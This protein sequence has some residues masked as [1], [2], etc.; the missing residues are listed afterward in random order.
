[1]VFRRFA[2]SKKS[3][4]FAPAFGK[5]KPSFEAQKTMRKHNKQQKI[6]L[7][8]RKFVKLPVRK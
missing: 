3:V 8:C 2:N 1:M 7:Q 5:G 4:T 6:I